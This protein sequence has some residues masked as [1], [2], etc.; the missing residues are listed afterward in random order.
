M[1]REEFEQ[2]AKR[3]ADCGHWA[4]VKP[5]NPAKGWESEHPKMKTDTEP[6]CVLAV[7]CEVKNGQG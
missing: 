4:V 7:Y 2:V 5:A 1:W 3:R 6:Y